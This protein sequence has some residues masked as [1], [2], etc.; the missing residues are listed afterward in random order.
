MQLQRAKLAE[1]VVKKQRL[2]SF[3][4]PYFSVS[5]KRADARTR[6]ICS[7]KVPGS[8]SL[9]PGAENRKWAEMGII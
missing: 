7:A 5:D 6:A 2:E 4:D 9:C 1:E 3:A 8:L